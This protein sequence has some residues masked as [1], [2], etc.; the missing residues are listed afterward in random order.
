MQTQIE[1][2]QTFYTIWDSIPFIALPSVVAQ[3]EMGFDY[4]ERDETFA[5]RFD[6]DYSRECV[7][8]VIRAIQ[9]SVAEIM[10]F[11]ELLYAYQDEARALE[12]EAREYP[13]IR[14]R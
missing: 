11:E 3:V 1:T 6:T 8:T 10:A 9:A 2:P 5:P 14:V 7:S 12:R 4:E 13:E